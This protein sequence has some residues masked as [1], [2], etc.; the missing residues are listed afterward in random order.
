MTPTPGQPLSEADVSLLQP[1]D[2]LLH[3]G[4]SAVRFHTLYGYVGE[5]KVVVTDAAGSFQDY[6]GFF[7]FLGR[8]DQDGWIEGSAYPDGLCI[9]VKWKHDRPWLGRD[10]A[11]TF[12]RI[13]VT[14]WRPHAPVSH[15]GDGVEGE[16]EQ[17]LRDNL[18]VV[19]TA[20]EDM[21]KIGIQVARTNKNYATEDRD[22]A[23]IDFIGEVC[24]RWAQSSLTPPAEP[25]SRPA[26][27]GEATDNLVD[28]FAE[29]LKA[30]L[31]AAGEKYGFGDA[32]KHD[33]W[34]E[35]LIEDLWRH[36]QKG[37]PR[38]VAAYCAFAWYHGWS[39][40]L[41]EPMGP[42]FFSDQNAE[43]RYVG[44]G[45]REAVARITGDDLHEI[46]A[47]FDDLTDLGG[48][49]TKINE[50]LAL[51]SPAAPDAGGGWMPIETAPKD[52]TEI[53]VAPHMTVVAWDFGAEQWVVGIIPLNRDRTIADDW[54]VQ[55]A[56]MFE[57]YLSNWGVEPTH[58]MP[59]PAP[60]ALQPGGEQ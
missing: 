11:H 44:K 12:E 10:D 50:R 38:D 53:L 42:I 39:L 2:W 59:L 16:R 7:T 32:W 57:Q 31:R 45:E 55:P 3:T 60:P 34:R 29:A 41:G 15:P 23:R 21:A 40:S 43:A 58:W 52:G 46:L 17:Y 36:V 14:H 37:D 6:H 28:R 27:E 18:D 5:Q 9:D 20:V 30:K 48:M 25:V 13:Q 35:K 51:L 22:R 54:T 4:R 1:G 26:G 47:S 33:D 56:M 8:P 19:W 49:A 24:R